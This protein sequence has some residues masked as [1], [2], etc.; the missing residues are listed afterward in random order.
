MPAP[1]TPSFAERLGRGTPFVSTEACQ[2]DLV[3]VG[4]VLV[5]PGGSHMRIVRDRSGALRIELSPPSEGD[6]LRYTPSADALFTS[7]AEVMGDRVVAAVL[8][9]MGSD[10]LRGLADVK[11][12]GGLVLA[13]SRESA[14]V[15]GMPRLAAESGEVDEVLPVEKIAE[16]IA[17]FVAEAKP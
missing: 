4:R 7:A 17:R 12:A 10:S 2:G 14:A 1:L 11:R 6:G 13:Q 3:A 15:W 8:T 16:R 5:A 9:G